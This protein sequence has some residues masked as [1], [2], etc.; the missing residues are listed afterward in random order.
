MIGSLNLTSIM[1]TLSS[2]LQTPVIFI[3]L[4]LAVITVLMLGTLAGETLTER[5]YV[6][7]HS[8]EIPEIIKAIR[9]GEMTVNE[10]IANKGFLNRQK[11]LLQEVVSHK[12]LTDAER[13]SYAM[14][15]LTKY[16]AFLDR[17]VK[18]TDMIAKIGP[19]FGLMGT[20]IP[21]GPGIIALGQGDTFTLSNS[22]MIAFDTTVTGLICAAAALL[23][24]SIRKHWYRNDMSLM[25][26]LTECILEEVRQDV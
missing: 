14:R 11:E 21:L 7:R 4:V 3:L 12:E 9:H 20:L 5:I 24:S 1:R 8:P 22:L 18:I 13:E 23:T 16:K 15:L 6:W 2:S 10:C 25:E 26:T 17:R 19:M